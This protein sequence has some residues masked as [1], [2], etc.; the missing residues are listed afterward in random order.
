M[1]TLFPTTLASHRRTSRKGAN[2]A[3]LDF[4][5]PHYESELTPEGMKLS[6]YM[7]SVEANGIEIIVRGPDLTIIG[8]KRHLVRVNFESANLE[9]VQRDYELRLRLGRDLD[10]ASVE[11]ELT[12]GVLTL[13]VPRRHL[14][15]A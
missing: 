4:I 1:N 14:R 8:R 6:V 10:F 15:A 13:S 2:T 3:G 12:D 11:A 7:P 9:G 5:S